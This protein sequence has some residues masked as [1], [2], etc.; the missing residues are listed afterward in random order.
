MFLNVIIILFLALMVAI[1][2]HYGFFSA[3]LHLLVTIFAGTLALALWEPMV[4]WIQFGAEDA[5]GVENAWGTWL[6]ALFFLILLLLRF[7]MDKL[8][9][10]NVNFGQIVDMVGGGACGLVAGMLTAGLTVI[11]LGFLPLGASILGHQPLV[12]QSDGA[13]EVNRGL[14]VPVDRFAAGLFTRL[15]DTSFY[16]GKPM[17][18][19]LPDLARRAQEFNLLVDPNGTVTAAPKSLKVP[20]VFLVPQ[21]PKNIDQRILEALENH[22]LN[23]D[24]QLVLIKTAIGN[25]LPPRDIDAQLRIPPSQVRL[26]VQE[27]P[28]PRRR[29]T[30]VYPPIAFVKEDS[31]GEQKT[32]ELVDNNRD[33]ADS[34]ATNDAIFT[35]VFVIPKAGDP[36]PEFLWFRRLRLELPDSTGVGKIDNALGHWPGGEIEATGDSGNTSSRFGESDGGVTRGHGPAHIE[37]IS[38]LPITVNRNMTG[39]LRIDR[40]NRITGGSEIVRQGTGRIPK[41]R[42]ITSIFVA[43][44]HICI[45]LRIT[46]DKARS[47]LGHAVQRAGQLNAPF[48]RDQRHDTHTPFAYVWRKS[49]RDQKIHIAPTGLIRTAIELPVGDMRKGD[50]LFLY[51][52]IEKNARLQIVSYNIGDQKWDLNKPLDIP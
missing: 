34:P 35:W 42:R 13:V 51:F 19:Y 27:T 31:F 33:S 45:R 25:Q 46:Q 7:A 48:L 21:R 40:H 18:L 17:S 23:S 8:V 29:R 32:F 6:L 1:W 3:T 41:E 44:Q 26:I 38:A 28:S 30:A 43:D 15:S 16:S 50:D 2:S 49:N 5:W 24:S 11:G 20:D 22:G 9:K 37:L 47:M 14:W 12:V 52:R 10:S 39:R 36:K 4:Y